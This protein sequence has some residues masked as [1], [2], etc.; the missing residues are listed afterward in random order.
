[1]QLARRS[2]TLGDKIFTFGDV[3]ANF[4][5][6]R[7]VM[8]V[9]EGNEVSDALLAHVGEVHRRAGQV[10]GGYPGERTIIAL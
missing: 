2:L 10:L 6:G 7:N 8:F 4:S 1:M 9:A 5:S 3:A